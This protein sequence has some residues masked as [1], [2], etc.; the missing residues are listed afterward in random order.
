MGQYDL[1]QDDHAQI[2]V[3]AYA[4][5]QWAPGQDAPEQNSPLASITWP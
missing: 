3:Q 2:N 1:D 4:A 5:E